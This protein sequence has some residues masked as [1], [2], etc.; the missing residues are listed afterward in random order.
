[1]E[2]PSRTRGRPIGL[3]SGR[4]VDVN[5]GPLASLPRPKSPYL[6]GRC[7]AVNVHFSRLSPSSDV[8]PFRYT[9]AAAELRSLLAQ[10]SKMAAPNAVPRRVARLDPSPSLSTLLDALRAFWRAR[11][12]PSLVD[13]GHRFREPCHSVRHRRRLLREAAIQGQTLHIEHR[14]RLPARAQQ[15]P[16]PFRCRHPGSPRGKHKSPEPRLTPWVLG[17][18]C[19]S[20]VSGL[21]I[22][23][24]SDRWPLHR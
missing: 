15:L 18:G 8:Y 22:V 4:Y 12:P 3:G 5:R 19:S 11:L 6:P 24:G 21:W 9:G 23:E 10:P 13:E 17:S 7:V 14:Q 16:R 20:S 2:T 1:M